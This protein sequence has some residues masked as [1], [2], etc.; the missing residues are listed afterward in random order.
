MHTPA[1][2]SGFVY[3]FIHFKPLGMKSI[4]AFGYTLFI[5]FI[6]HPLNAQTINQKYTHANGQEV[7]VGKC[8]RSALLMGQYA[9]WFQNN[10]ASYTVDSATCTYIRPLLEHKKITVF[11]GTWCGDS[12]RELPRLLK[13]LDCCGFPEDKVQLI[14]VSNASDAY[15]QSPQHEEQGKN[16]LRVPTIIIEE[17]QKEIGRIIEYPVVSLE[18]DLLKILRKEAYKPNYSN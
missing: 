15:K 18:K 17:H 12:Q 9:A 1:C 10:Y 11:M 13:M 14:M 5:L 2:R 7:L 6:T 16:I 4:L 3:S 8:T